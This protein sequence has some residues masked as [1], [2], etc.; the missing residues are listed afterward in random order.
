M[1]SLKYQRFKTSG[2]RAIG[3]R[4]LDFVKNSRFLYGVLK[5]KNADYLSLWKV[6]LKI[7]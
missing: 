5:T 7:Y 3:I 2:C 6:F 1:Y 4:K